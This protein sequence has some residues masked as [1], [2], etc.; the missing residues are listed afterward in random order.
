VTRLIEP[1]TADPFDVTEMPLFPLFV[2]VVSVINSELDPFGA[3]L[4]PEFLKLR[5]T[6]L[7]MFND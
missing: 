3:K 7:W 5:T 1:L 6:D 2:T 4:M